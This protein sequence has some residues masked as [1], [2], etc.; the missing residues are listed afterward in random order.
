MSVPDAVISDLVLPNTLPSAEP[1]DSILFMAQLVKAADDL[2]SDPALAKIAAQ[3]L[4][5]FKMAAAIISDAADSKDAEY[6][7]IKVKYGI[8]ISG[9]RELAKVLKD[10][11]QKKQA[12]KILDKVT[13][14]KY[15][16]TETIKTAFSNV[17]VW[18]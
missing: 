18:G 10:V 15:N 3:D 5:F 2:K 17:T 13:D 1:D 7:A 11:A 14:S 6:Q 16:G 4:K 9:V 8:G 12:E